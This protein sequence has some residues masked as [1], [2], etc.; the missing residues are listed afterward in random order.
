MDPIFILEVVVV[1][2]L[3][4][5]DVDVLPVDSFGRRDRPPY[6]LDFHFGTLYLRCWGLIRYGVWRSASFD[7]GPFRHFN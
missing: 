7:W 5:E 1:A 3:F 2:F 6:W 4:L